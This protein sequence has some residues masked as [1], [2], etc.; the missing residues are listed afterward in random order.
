MINPHILLAPL[1]AKEAV[2]SSK[3][4]GIQVSFTELLQFEA[5]EKLKD[6]TNVNDMDEILNYKKAIL[7][8]EKMFEDR[9]FIH[10]NM[11][12]N[13]HSILLSGVR[14]NNKDKAWKNHW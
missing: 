8:A 4:E 1:T 5:D 3:I 14:G 12:K 2:L 6:G 9:P 11:V 7:K 10:L 13:L